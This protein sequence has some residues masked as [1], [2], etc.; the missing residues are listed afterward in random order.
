M[1][2]LGD[3]RLSK[4]R[5]Q[6]LFLVVGIPLISLCLTIVVLN[7][8]VKPRPQPGITAN[9]PPVAVK[10]SPVVQTASIPVQLEIPSINLKTPIKQAGLA[11]N[12]DMA[13]DD[14]IDSVAWYQ[15]GPHPGEKGSAVIAGHYGWKNG[16]ASIFNELHTLKAGDSVIVHDEN[17][18][19]TSFIV[20]EIRAYDPNADATEVFKST[21]GKAHLNLIT[22]IGTWN[23]SRQTYSERLVVFTEKVDQLT[24]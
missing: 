3:R 5:R 24:T 12:G 21:D 20:R 23:N 22:C 16:Q 8:F 11:A 13:I 2:S 4:K 1:N 14:S 7:T 6:R 19:A 9:N 10:L 15:A 17:Q 18:I